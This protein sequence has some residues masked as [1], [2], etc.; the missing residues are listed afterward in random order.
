MNREQLI[1]E[2]TRLNPNE[3]REDVEDELMPLIDQ[4]AER[5]ESEA[6]IDELKHLVDDDGIWCQDMTRQFP[7]KIRL[8]ERIKELEV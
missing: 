2:L 1:V 3:S 5:V 7:Q 4:Y 8:D 6:R